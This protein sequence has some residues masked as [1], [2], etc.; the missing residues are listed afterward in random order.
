[1]KMRMKPPML[2]PTR[3]KTFLLRTESRQRMSM[4]PRLTSISRPGTTDTSTGSTRSTS[5]PGRESKKSSL[6]IQ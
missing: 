6:P 1:M 5:L 2:L 4:L 3:L